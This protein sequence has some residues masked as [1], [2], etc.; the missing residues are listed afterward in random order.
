MS[1]IDKWFIGPVPQFTPRDLGIPTEDTRPMNLVLEQIRNVA[2]DPERLNW[3]AV[4]CLRHSGCIIDRIF[5]S[6]MHKDLSHLDR[7]L[8]ALVQELAIRCQRIFSRAGA[9][10][11]RSA[12]I[13][14]E[15]L[16]IAFGVPR[17]EHERWPS[18]TRKIRERISSNKVRD[19][20]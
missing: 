15:H 5:K 7:N 3:Q 20:T 1:S 19:Q 12:T 2:G 17:A 4:G 9:A 10:T 13:I 14:A 16:S 11:S 8:D 18:D 6:G